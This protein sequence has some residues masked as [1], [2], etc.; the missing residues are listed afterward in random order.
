MSSVVLKANSIS[1]LINSTKSCIWQLV[2]TILV[3]SSR[4]NPWA[5]RGCA[6]E[7][8]QIRD[9]PRKNGILDKT[10]IPAESLWKFLFLGFSESLL[11]FNFLNILFLLSPL[12]F[13]FLFD[14]HSL[15][16][17]SFSWTRKKDIPIYVY[18]RVSLLREPAF[19]ALEKWYGLLI[20][21]AIGFKSGA[22]V[23]KRRGIRAN[24]RVNYF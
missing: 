21:R 18:T 12:L 4:L 5:V 15:I 10:A 9:D 6:N 17:F 24:V 11:K 19:S 22:S 20:P 13:Y 8:C 23:A 16:S 3:I 2:Y 7:Q 14:S 1:R